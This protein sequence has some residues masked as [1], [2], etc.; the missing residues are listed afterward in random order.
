MST[1]LTAAAGEGAEELAQARAL[2]EHAPDAVVVLDCDA[3]RF[4]SVNAAAEHLFGMDRARLLRVGPID[5]SPPRQPDGRDSAEAAHAW[6]ELALAGGRPR[7]EWI[8]QR[9]DGTGVPCEITLL[10]LPST[11]RR[12][13][14]GSIVDVTE[15]RA[16]EAARATAVAEQAARR[17]A[18]TGRA[19]LEALVA[20][21]NAVVWERDPHTLRFSYLN[22]RVEELLGYPVAQWLADPGLW[23]RILHPHDRAEVVRRVRQAV[24]GDETDFALTYRARTRGGRWLWL[25]HL[26]HVA[27]DEDGRA[28]SLH[29]VLVDVTAARRRE[30]A[31][32]LLAAAGRALAAD[33]PVE[34]RLGAVAELALGVLG[35]T[36]V[37]WLAGDDDTYRMVAA[38]PPEVA[39]QVR[40]MP[41]V[42]A[43]RQLRPL[44]AAGRP[45]AVDP[46]SEPMRREALHGDPALERLAAADP[47]PRRQLVV[48]LLDGDQPIGLLSVYTTDLSRRFDDDDLAL[49]EDLGQ[50]IATMVA[51]ER[52][53]A[54]QRQLHELT[55]AL[56][57]AGTVAEAAAAL[58]DGLHRA[59]AASVV[60]VCTLAPDG[61]LHTLQAHG[62]PTERLARFA[63]MRLAAPFPLATAART[64]RAVWLA[65]RSAVVRRFPGVAPHLQATTQ[66]TAALPL[67]AADR[68]LGALGVTFTT[69]RRFDDGERTFLRTVAD[70]LAVALER[71][72]LADV[73]R[74]MAEVLQR[75]LLP[76]RV[77][78]V[79]GLEVVTRY[80]P[81]VRGTA[82]GGDWYDLHHL[83]DGRVAVAVG[84]TVGHGSA[85]A[86]VM[87]VLRSSLAALLVAGH[88]PAEALTLLDRIADDVPGAAVSTV[89]CLRLHPATGELSYSRAGHP[90]PL[91]TDADGGI[92]WL[93]G[94]PGRALGLPDHSARPEARTVLPAGATLLS[95]TD[96]L[97]ERHDDDLDAGLARLA[98]AATAR[99][100]APLAALVDGV[101]A[102]LVDVGGA[103][104]DIAIV[105]VRRADAASDA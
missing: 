46:L 12:L 59:L 14:R 24:A 78:D 77:P 64:G 67:L 98:G 72:T 92:T 94:A 18:E 35:E 60:A 32:A 53:T 34:Q 76:A 102:D 71:A 85:A 86:A 43:P 11:D 56:S 100:A 48:P 37:V 50:R 83:P 90:P 73:R 6:I 2:I 4:T 93:D 3:G 54:R 84:D 9:A 21:L 16:T 51:T 36:A 47:T 101:L 45:F 52:V 39:V 88:P 97:I 75:S 82:A 55:A 49:A 40:G 26:G 87:G 23:E 65:D 62:Y 74:E 27:R 25:Q 58:A 42:L 33:G 31:A 91:L 10:R 105:A 17:A 89:A 68:V 19:R 69:P 80:L 103:G 63:T 1:D 95:F 7:F 13:V 20:G 61:L 8:H 66:A 29:V 28:R 15:R 22:D 57:A 104:D 41:P 5:V 99:R 70:Q 38:A 44:I 79:D 81:A 96:G 30:Q